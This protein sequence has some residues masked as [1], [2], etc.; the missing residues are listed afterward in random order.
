MVR[1][2]IENVHEKLEAA[3][4]EFLQNVECLIN[5]A[6]QACSWKVG[7]MQVHKAR[8]YVVI[9]I[10]SRYLEHSIYV[11]KCSTMLWLMLIM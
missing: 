6:L 3:P 2:A 8:Y 5:D 9:D 10:I 4:S 11:W 7:N 1:M